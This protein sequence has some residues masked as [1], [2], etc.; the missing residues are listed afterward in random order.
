MNFVIEMFCVVI[1]GFLKNF[2][3]GV[4]HFAQFNGIAQLSKVLATKE[5]ASK[6]K[7]VFLLTQLMK[8]HRFLQDTLRESGTLQLIANQLT[9]EQDLDLHEKVLPHFSFS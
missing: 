8:E 4:E 5:L 3:E 1:S 2:K 7:I 6:R 9:E